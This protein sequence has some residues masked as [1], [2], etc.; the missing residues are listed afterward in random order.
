MF[1]K[2]IVGLS[3]VA[4]VAAQSSNDTIDP[5]SVDAVMRSQWC[6]AEI[7]TCGTL[8]SGAIDANTCDTSS[9]NYTCTCSS[10]GSTPGL[11]YYKQTMPT[12]ICETIYANCIAAGENDAAAQKLCKETEAKNCGQLDPDKFTAPA[13]T[14]ASST[15]S[16]TATSTSAASATSASASAA[17]SSAAASA[18]NIGHEFGTGIFAAGFAAVFGLML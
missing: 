10:N 3:I 6:T 15:A 2:S 14:S 8:C 11:Q 4:L 16:A 7:N 18:L 5:N 17:T 1:I 9:L 12:Y 13:T